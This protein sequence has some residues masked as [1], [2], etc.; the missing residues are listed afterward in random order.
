MMH[1][2]VAR[3]CSQTPACQSNVLERTA[4]VPGCGCLHTQGSLRTRLKEPNTYKH[5]YMFIPIVN[6]SI[7][8]LECHVGVDAGGGVGADSGGGLLL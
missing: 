4:Q 7:V 1:S 2:D 8:W 3:G 6:L 5:A